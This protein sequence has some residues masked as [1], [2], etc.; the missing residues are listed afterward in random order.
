MLSVVAIC[1]NEL[2]NVDGFISSWSDVADEIIIVDTGSKD[3][4][5]AAL[6][7]NENYSTKLRVYE[8]EWVQD[9]S[10]ARN[11]AASNALG[12]W[13]L[14]ADMDDRVHVGSIPRIRELV[15]TRD[16]AYAFQVAS[17]V[18]NGGWHRFMQVR[19][20]PNRPSVKFRNVVHET[21]DVS[22]KL[23]DLPVYKEPEIMIAHLGYA[24]ENVKKHKAI[25]NL[26]LL[27]HNSD[28]TTADQFAQ[29][30]DALYVLG[31]FSVGI[32]YY[33][34]AVRLGGEGAEEVLAEKLIVG[35]LMLGA[36]DKAKKVIHKLDKYSIAANYW[37][38]EILRAEG[39][40]AKAKMHFERAITGTRHLDVREC[41]GDT[42]ILNSKDRLKELEALCV[43]A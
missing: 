22:L 12:T 7:A 34:Q 29:V 20:Y 27:L 41:N 39:M 42:M 25:R 1:K 36:L 15:R 21:L 31:K 24:D 32:G 19:M 6:R 43:L 30:G 40:L 38:G 35:Y 37:L 2:S 14:W 8:M 33:E 13:I 17:D 9:F 10:A 11:Y 16:C 23:A 28:P 4:T 26:D 18:G 5:L 3:G